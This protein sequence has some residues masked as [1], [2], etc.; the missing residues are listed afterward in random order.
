[1]P[2]KAFI[3]DMDGTILHTLPDLALAANEALERMG[4]PA[5]TYDEIHAFMGQGS[6]RLIEM[7]CPESATPAQRR[8]T[9]EVWR[10]IYL[11]S[12]YAHTEPFPGITEAIRELRER[13]VKTAVLSNKFD[14]GVQVLAQR[15]FPGLFDASRGEIPPTPRKPDPTG[16]N[17][18]IGRLGV[19]PSCVAYV[20]DSGSD[21]TV[22]HAAG[23]A[24]IGV[25]WGYRSVDVLRAAGADMLVDAPAQL[26]NEAHQSDRKEQR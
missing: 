19:D 4:F 23:C 7:C 17:A 16:L 8:Q 26:Y 2:F 20:G 6:N 15:F 12:A 1:M 21:M 22:A 14:A 10:S 11:Q 5:R 24:A 9:F 18:M 3:F 13:G 25:T